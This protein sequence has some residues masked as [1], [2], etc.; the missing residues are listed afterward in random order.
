MVK[1]HQKPEVLDL[2]L[3]IPGVYVRKCEAKKN[4]RLKA[5]VSTKAKKS[6]NAS[7]T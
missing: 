1:T 5:L 6:V 3:Q 4:Q 7:V 2:M